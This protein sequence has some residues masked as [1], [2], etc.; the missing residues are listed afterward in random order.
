MLLGEPPRDV[1]V[2]Y[3]EAVLS[4]LIER[5]S[6]RWSH[7]VYIPY[8]LLGTWREEL[9]KRDDPQLTALYTQSLPF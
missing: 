5:V 9:R 7:L 6:E 4:A 8:A 3:G 1:E 2:G